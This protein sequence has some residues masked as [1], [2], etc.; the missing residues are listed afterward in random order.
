M[1]FALIAAAALSITAP[2]AVLADGPPAPDAD[3]YVWLEDVHGAKPLEWVEKE[4]ARSL[5]VLKGDPR[6]EPFH[7]ETLKLVNATDRIPGPMLIGA[8]VYN[9]WQDEKN[10]RGLWRR[11]SPASYA[12]AEPKWETVIDLDQ[13]SAAEHANWVWQGASCPP[14]YKR[15][16]VVLSDGG[17]DATEV[18]EFDPATKSFV[19][20][21]FRLPRSK[22]DADWLDDDTLILDRDWG[23]GTMTESGYGFVV[24]TWKRG[25]ALD[26]ATEVFRGKPEDVSASPTVMHDPQGGRLALIVRAVSF[27][28]TETYVVTAK[29]VVKTPLPLKH[30][31]RGLLGGRVLLT[32]EQEWTP[33]PGAPAIPQGALI[34][35]DAKD[36]EAGR[37]PKIETLLVPGPRQ[38]I[39]QLE[40]TKNR[41]VVE[42]YD[43][44]R[45]VLQSYARGPQGWT[46]AT[47]P[48]AANSAVDL[49]TASDLDDSLYYVVESF[50]EPTKLWRAD[51]ATGERTTVKELPA[52]FD[53]SKDAV[54]QLEAASSDGTKIPYFVVGPKG[55]KRDGSNPTLLYAY[56]GFQVSETP[57][58]S[59]AL[60]K[61]W[62]ER[63][64]VYV[65]ANIRGGGEF[66][67]AWH[68][69]G[70][71]TH[72]Q[73][74][75]DDFAAVAKDL[76]ARGITSPRRLG[77][78]GG[79]NGGL[80]MGVQLIQH[81]ELWRAVLIE[82]P[83]L[84]MLR[85][86]KIGAGASWVGEYGSSEV[87]EEAAFLRKISPYHNL[88]AGVAY[89]EPFFVTAT[90]DDR[91]TPVHARKMAAKM[92][93]MGLP[94]LF[95]ENTNGGH[96]A[97]ANLQE[98]AV[99]KALEFT[100]LT[101]KLMD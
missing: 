25:Q 20:G 71:K 27:F 5:A 86:E 15:C 91:V 58:Y 32:V 9:F 14:P 63:G 85:I 76:I 33:A 62:L 36:L 57:T 3:P 74:I 28:E 61:L 49:A 83:L 10:V 23:P 37:P 79:S 12:T 53:A 72:R 68:D 82:V 67:P 8:D 24:K 65:L 43:N 6:Y 42:L 97:S 50:L 13:L 41:V 96:A 21:G 44:V 40:L 19:A 26:Q 48:V 46:M 38:S 100:Y 54:E 51:A 64:G 69:A 18:R 89:P 75:Y 78:Q 59:G 90:S 4:N 31:L 66:G 16:L 22:Q 7:Q 88:K 98:V 17:E 80:L 2:L 84:D 30:T 47:L 1:R 101:R 29:G 39:E 34:A 11:T 99:Q 70:L 93:E 92:K 87:P 60:G 81:P 35:V 95:Y 94:F 73:L 55:M 45:G 52:R 56:G 77:I